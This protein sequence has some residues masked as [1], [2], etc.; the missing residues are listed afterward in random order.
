MESAGTFTF[1]NDG[2]DVV[3]HRWLPSGSAKA[4][5]LI[6]HG[7]AEHAARYA[8]FAG[9]LNAAGY[10]V[11]APDLRGALKRGG[12]LTRDSRVV[13]RK[14]YGRAKARRSFQFSKR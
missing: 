11:Y 13:E 14:K 12:F 7:M 2:V 4:V 3:V 8:R 6:A 9:A 10:A 1:H 5:V